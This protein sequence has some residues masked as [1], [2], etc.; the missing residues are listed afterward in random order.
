MSEIIVKELFE[1]VYDFIESTILP[2]LHWNKFSDILVDYRHK[3]TTS[4][5]AYVDVLP[6]LTCVAAGGQ[7]KKA[8]PLAAAWSLYIL[9]A[10]IFDD[11]QDDEGVEHAW[12]EGGIK[13]ALPIGL[14][15]LGAANASLSHLTAEEG[16]QAAILSAFGNTLALSAKAQSER[17]TVDDLTVEW[18]FQILAAKTGLIFATGSWAG[19]FISA[20]SPDP[21]IVNSLYQYGLNTGMAAQITDDCYD[22]ADTDLPNNSLSLPIIYALSQKK[23]DKYPTLFSSLR[24]LGKKPDRIKVIMKCLQEM[25]AVEWSLKVAKIYESQALAALEPLPK[26]KVYPLIHYVSRDFP[27]SA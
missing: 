16:K 22:L 12:N 15:A 5:H 3:R 6:L 13:E 8:V 7:S 2:P 9:A 10:R 23:H 4:P 14:Y 26:E 27:V 24:E 18:Y 20:E 1:S 11:Q 19:A 21:A 17:P 25:K